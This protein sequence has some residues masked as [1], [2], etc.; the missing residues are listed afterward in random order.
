MY[1]LVSYVLARPANTEGFLEEMSHELKKL[2]SFH[3]FLRW[4]R[5]QFTGNFD[6]RLH[7]SRTMLLHM[8]G[9]KMAL[10]DV[11]VLIPRTCEYVT[12]SSKEELRL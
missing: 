8:V 9:R 10:R 5:L 12:S 11:Y 1:C 4:M 7:F 6:S 3:L 2:F